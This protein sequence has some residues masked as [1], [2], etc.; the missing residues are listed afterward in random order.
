MQKRYQTRR[1]TKTICTRL[2][3]WEADWRWSLNGIDGGG[4]VVGKDGKA[5]EEGSWSEA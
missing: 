4:L 5:E 3:S 1:D 2:R